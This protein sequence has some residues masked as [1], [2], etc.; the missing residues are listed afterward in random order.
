LGLLPFDFGYGYYTDNLT[1]RLRVLPLLNC[2]ARQAV[3]NSGVEYSRSSFP[4]YFFYPNSMSRNLP[5]VVSIFLV[6]LVIAALGFLV[7]ANDS[8]VKSQPVEKDFLVPWLGARTFL[9]Y[10][11][12]PYSA[13]AAQRA[14]VVTYGRLAAAGQDPLQLWLPFP[15]ELLYFPI[16]LIPDYVLARAIWMTL[17]EIALFGVV[18]LTLQLTGWNPGRFFMPVLLLFPFLWVYGIFSLVSASAA[19]FVALAAAGFL[20]AVRAERDELAG[21]LLIL[22][23]S[24]PR[25]TGV[26][27]FFVFW[28]IIHQ[29]RWRILGGFF[30][31]AT[32]LIVLSF[33]FQPDW[34]LPF[35]RGLLSYFAFGPGYTSIGI[36]ASWSPVVGQ[37]IGWVLAA[38]FF[39][40]LFFEWGRTLSGDF[41]AFLWMVC[42]TLCV[43]PLLGVPVVPGDYP[44]LFIPLLLFLAILS[45]RRPT[46]KSWGVSQIVLL[47]LLAGFWLLAILQIRANAFVSLVNSLVL[48]LP[49]LLAAGLTWMRWWFVHTVPTGLGSPS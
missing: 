29:R 41:R 17:L 43:T 46:F 24:A 42:L 40:I 16:A 34:F 30:M 47:L 25:L 7:W 39:L 31:G 4:L 8:F 28:W 36:F 21:G 38:L 49:I 19:G 26:L 48:L 13:P 45:E 35:L 23:V 14:Q 2:K 3:C 6:L 33:L 5:V 44:I 32:V 15:V 11:T 20:L 12:S 10:G 9:Q 22:L 37:R 1:R 18:F 27:A